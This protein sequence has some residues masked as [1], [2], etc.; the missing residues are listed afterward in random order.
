M[1]EG[2][3]ELHTSA[4]KLKNVVL[5]STRGGGLFQPFVEIGAMLKKGQVIDEIVR[6]NGEVVET[7]KSPING[8]LIC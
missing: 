7:L 3:P 4:R 6:L 1:L 8:V 5:V 2:K